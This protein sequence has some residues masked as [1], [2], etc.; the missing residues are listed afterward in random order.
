M[1]ISATKAAPSTT[2]TAGKKPV[3]P[4]PAL[5]R[6]EQ[7]QKRLLVKPL[8][9]QKDS[10]SRATATAMASELLLEEAKIYKNLLPLPL[11]KL[12]LLIQLFRRAILGDTVHNEEI[13]ALEPAHTMLRHA[14]AWEMTG[15]GRKELSPLSVMQYRVALGREA[16]AEAIRDAV[17]MQTYGQGRWKQAAAPTR[18]EEAPRVYDGE[19]PFPSTGDSENPQRNSELH[20]THARI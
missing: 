4:D 8:M 6:L 2:K 16:L 3:K 14:H 18:L 10:S 17:S 5:G 19:Q 7:I 9:G 12:K 15:S 20:R 1:P 13:K 11:N